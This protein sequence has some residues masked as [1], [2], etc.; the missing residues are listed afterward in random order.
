LIG[1]GLAALR[2]YIGANLDRVHSVAVPALGC[3]LGG[4]DW[5]PVRALIESRLAGFDD[6]HVRLYPPPRGPKK[7]GPS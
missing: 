2:G 1:V 6:L 3:G 5:P 4:L 7:L